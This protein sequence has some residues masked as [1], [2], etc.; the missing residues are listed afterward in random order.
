MREIKFRI[1]YKGKINGYELLTPNGWEWS[2][3][4]LNPF[5]GKDHWCRGVFPYGYEYI[6]NQFTGLK[7]KNGVEIYEGDILT[8][9][10]C[11]ITEYCDWMEKPAYIVDYYNGY[12]LS[13]KGIDKNLFLHGHR[14]KY[15]KVIGNI[16]E[17]PELN[18]IQHVKNILTKP[19]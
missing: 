18:S 13:G 9:D 19:D 11:G 6:R 16:Y 8:W 3:I 15:T 2:C 7:D 1:I 17:N 12:V 5:K 10:Y 14:F 4:D